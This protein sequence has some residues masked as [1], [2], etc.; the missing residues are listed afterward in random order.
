MEESSA[1]AGEQ[2]RGGATEGE[3]FD[4]RDLIQ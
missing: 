3:G 1:A 4:E 2:S